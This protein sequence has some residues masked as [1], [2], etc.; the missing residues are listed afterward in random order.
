MTDVKSVHTINSSVLT[1][2]IGDLVLDVA[3]VHR[4]CGVQAIHPRPSPALY[5]AYACHFVVLVSLQVCCTI[6]VPTLRPRTTQLQLT[7]TIIA[8]HGSFSPMPHRGHNF[9]QIFMD[10]ALVPSQGWLRITENIKPLHEIFDAEATCLHSLSLVRIKQGVIR[11]T[12]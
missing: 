7:I 4:C 8:H 5:E 11:S 1:H 10:L 12:L 3:A 2:H 6:R 9:M